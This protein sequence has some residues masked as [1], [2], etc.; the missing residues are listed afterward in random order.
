MAIRYGA[1]GGR[2]GRPPAQVG[3]L[4]EADRLRLMIALA[5]LDLDV[6]RASGDQRSMEQHEQEI[7]DRQRDLSAL[8]VGAL[9]T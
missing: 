1:R 2:I 9:V 6:A 4:T 3:P 5:K 7:A 8:P